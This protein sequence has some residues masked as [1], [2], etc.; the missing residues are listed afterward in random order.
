[1]SKRVFLSLHP[2]KLYCLIAILDTI[3]FFVV[4]QRPC[5]PPPL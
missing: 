4:M 1:M 2:T 3:A 5:H